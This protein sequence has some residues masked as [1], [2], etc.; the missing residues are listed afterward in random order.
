MTV[1]AQL[2]S[3]LCV[4]FS[5]SLLALV[6]L[7]S[8]AYA[9][10]TDPDK[11]EKLSPKELTGLLDRSDRQV[12]YGGVMVAAGDTLAG[13]VVIV[14]G[15]LDIQNGGVLDGDAWVINGQLILTGTAR[16]NGRVD[17]VNSADFRSFQAEVTGGVTQ[18]RCE[19]RLDAP[20]YEKDGIL[21]FEKHEDPTIVRTRPTLGLGGGNRVDAGTAEVGLQRI[22]KLHKKPYT[23][24]RAMVQFPWSNNTR[25]YLG[26][27][28]DLAVPLR[29]HK[30]DLLIRGFK[31]TYTNDYW[32]IDQTESG[33]IMALAAVDYPD[34]Y[35]RQGGELG[36]KYHPSDCLR[37]ET[38]VSFQREV[39]LKANSSSSWFYPNHKLR[40]NPAIDEGERLAVSTSVVFDTREEPVRPGD[41]WRLSGTVEKGIADGPGDFSYTTATADVRRYNLLPLGLRLAA[42]ARIFTTFDR[43]PRQVTQSMNGY[44]GVRG[45]A[46]DPFAVHRGDRLALI[47][48]EL[49]APL[50]ELPVFRWLFS[51]WDLV[52]FSDIGMLTQAENGKAPLRFLDTPFDQWKKSAG[53]GISG[54]SFLPYFGVYVAQDLD[55]ERKGARVIV[56]MH[57]SF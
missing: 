41:A 10:D 18:Y 20:R 11:I 45:L 15:A 6:V 34:Y 42:R 30:L 39:S 23:R 37:L 7:G 24:G 47:S 55:R 17:L 56:R 35:D 57:R 26:F 19:C 54:E 38:T 8:L 44:G 14:A 46:D 4:R 22:N 2:T 16:I 53:V 25:G 5:T 50:P 9:G 36:L 29:G 12:Y 13:P 48:G 40:A 43:I 21:L 1:R 33:W 49:R 51:R 52:V 3:T 28:M 32:Q 27:D 31:K